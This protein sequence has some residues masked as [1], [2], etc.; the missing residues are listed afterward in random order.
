MAN[1]RPH[2]WTGRPTG[3][4]IGNANARRH[5]LRQ[6]SFIG[7]RKLVTL[8]IREARALVREIRGS[9]VDRNGTASTTGDL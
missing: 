6:A 1:K 3:A 7:H 5:G 4:P 8:A 2:R 9:G